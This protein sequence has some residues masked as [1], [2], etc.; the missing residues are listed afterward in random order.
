MSAPTSKRR[1]SPN[2][3]RKWR[4]T[5]FIAVPA[6]LSFGVACRFHSCLP[7]IRAGGVKCRKA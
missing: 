6:N 2:P 3:N 7:T 1:G 4:P 5:V